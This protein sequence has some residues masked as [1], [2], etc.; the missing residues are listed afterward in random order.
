MTAALQEGRAGQRNARGAG[1]RG[2]GEIAAAFLRLGC[3]SF[4][5]P[6][7]H[8]GYLH[9]EFVVRRRWLNEEAYAERVALC[10]FLPGPSSSQVVFALGFLRGGLAG[11]LLASLCFTLPSALLMILFAYGFASFAGVGDAGWLRGLKLAAVAV[12]AHA[13]WGMGRQLCPDVPRVVLALA[14]AAGLVAAA[15]G[16]WVL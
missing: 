3:T 8:L 11:A 4:G 14:S 9:A 6:V 10:N 2:L 12:V 1:W 16:Q 13:V 15:A 5:G 7:A